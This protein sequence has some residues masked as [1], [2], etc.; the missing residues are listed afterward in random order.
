MRSQQVIFPL[1]FSEPSSFINHI[2]KFIRNYLKFFLVKYFFRKG[3]VLK[4]KGNLSGALYF[5]KQV[6]KIDSRNVNALNNL[7]VCCAEMGMYKEALNYFGKACAIKVDVDIIINMIVSAAKAG[8]KSIINYYCNKL[9]NYINT[10]DA[11][12]LFN[13]AGLMAQGKNYERAIYYYDLCA[14]RDHSFKIKAT[15]KK[16]ICYV[17]L[18]KYEEA[19]ACVEMLFSEEKGKKMAWELMGFIL[20]QLSCYAE[21][22]DCYNKAYGFE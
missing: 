3:L 15:Q 22:V 20:D 7:G 8:K 4:D 17:K 5:F 21:A 6:I 1:N 9:E 10:L 13:L 16:G 14:S 12:T 2:K 11:C 18:G 19:K